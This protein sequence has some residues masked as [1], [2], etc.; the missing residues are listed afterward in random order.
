MT[1]PKLV[2]AKVGRYFPLV[3]K[4]LPFESPEL[5]FAVAWSPPL[6]NDKGHMWFRTLIEKTANQL[7]ENL[8]K[9]TTNA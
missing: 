1:L 9:V 6:S 4:K 5:R 8:D 7:R 2:W 3:A